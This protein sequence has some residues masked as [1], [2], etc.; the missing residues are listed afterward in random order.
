MV[1]VLSGMLL[2]GLLTGGMYAAG[3]FLPHGYVVVIAGLV[4]LRFPVQVWMRR[5]VAAAAEDIELAAGSV[6]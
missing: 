6:A 5:R 1:L 2:S 4:A 3:R